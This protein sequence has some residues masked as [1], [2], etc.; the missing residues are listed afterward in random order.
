[1]VLLSSAKMSLTSESRFGVN[2]GLKG[3]VR[4]ATICALSEVSPDLTEDDFDLNKSYPC[5]QIPQHKKNLLAL[6]NRC[7]P[8]SLTGKCL[9][10]RVRLHQLWFD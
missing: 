6:Q 1:M 7:D 9:K 2:H 4:G 5:A 10:Q 3:N 8:G